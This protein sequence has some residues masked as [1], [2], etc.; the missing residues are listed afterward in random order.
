MAAPNSIS[1]HPDQVFTRWARRQPDPVQSLKD[2]KCKYFLNGDAFTKQLSANWI[3]LKFFVTFFGFCDRAHKEAWSCTLN[4]AQLTIHITQ[5]THYHKQLAFF[6]KIPVKAQW[7]QC[8]S[9]Q[10]CE[11]TKNC[12]N[13][14]ITAKAAPHKYPVKD[15]LTKKKLLFFWI[16]SKWGGGESPAKKKFLPFHKSIFGQ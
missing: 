3:F 12:W 7:L 1:F 9:S 11:R 15:V 4:L 10:V 5:D 6:V 2:L 14:T 16:L 13:I 8:G